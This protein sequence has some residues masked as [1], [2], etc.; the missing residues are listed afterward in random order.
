MK[1]W[2]LA[3]GLIV[4]IVTVAVAVTMLLLDM[5]ERKRERVQ[6]N[7]NWLVEFWNIARGYCVKVQFQNNT[8]IG[9]NELFPDNEI[10][11]GTNIDITVSRQ[12]CM[13]YEQDGVLLIWNLSAVNPADLNGY[14]L[15][16]PMVLR[17]GDR[18]KMG[19]SVFLVTRLEND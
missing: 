2:I 14:R 10:L 3:A 1:M 9:R 5:Q 12:H 18:L 4:L 6:E 15:N 13:L 19:N 11:H 17:S 16:S 8:V 7:S